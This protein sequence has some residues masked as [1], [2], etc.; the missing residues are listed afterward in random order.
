MRRTAMVFLAL[1][2]AVPMLAQQQAPPPEAILHEVLGLTDAQMTSLQQLEQARQ[3][4]VQ[5]LLP[6]LAQAQQG[7][8]AALNADPGDPLAIG[9]AMLAVRNLQRQ[10]EQAQTT[11]NEGFLALLTDAQRTQVQQIHGIEA[12]LHAAQALHALGL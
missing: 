2:I 10:I 12:A 6:Q 7:V 9:N 3:A 5:P 11:L 1:F 8:A 4:T